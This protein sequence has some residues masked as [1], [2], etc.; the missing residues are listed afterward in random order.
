MQRHPEA[1]RRRLE[2]ARDELAARVHAER[3]APDELLGAGPVGRITLPEAQALELG[4]S[5]P[6][7]SSG[8]PGRRGGSACAP[9]CPR[10]GT[11]GAST[12][13]GTAAARR[14][15]GST[16]SAG[17]GST[18]GRTPAAAG[19]RRSRRTAPTRRCASAPARGER[20][21]A[22]VEVACGTAFGQ[23][24]AIP[25]RTVGPAL[26]EQCELAAFDAEAW[27]LAHDF[28]V[29]QALEAHLDGDLEATWRGR[30]L[31][32]LNRFCDDRRG[33]ARSSASS[34]RRPTPRVVHE[35]S[36]VGHGAH[37][38]RLALA[39]GGDAPQVRAHVQLAL[40]ADGP[41]PRVP[42]RLLAGAAAT[43]GSRSA[44]RALR[45]ASASAVARGQWVPVGGTWVEPDCNLPSGES[46]VRQFLY[47]QRFFEREFGAPLPRVLEPGRLRL[48]R[49][50]AAAHARR[51]DRRAS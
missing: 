28:A 8:R 41:L 3:R 7:S 51:R 12:C 33:G 4:R 44:T 38:H 49:P 40:R 22:W 37:R 43:R 18:P 23:E 29:L 5:R 6:G 35:L 48:Q 1:T 20:L 17:K 47:G 11:A 50:A 30:L 34:W 24:G 42:L 31:H 15:C 39:G 45:R 13:C 26:L 27:E 21:E 25:L 16:A 36:A 19:W 46:L 2:R 14:R 9:P 32:E 10:R